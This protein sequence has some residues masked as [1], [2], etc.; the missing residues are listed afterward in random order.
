MLG[1]EYDEDW[2]D[3]YQVNDSEIVNLAKKFRKEL[4]EKYGK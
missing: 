4:E 2:D 3:V 1:K